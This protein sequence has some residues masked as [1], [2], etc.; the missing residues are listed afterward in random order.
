[1]HGRVIEHQNSESFFT[2]PL[3]E[4]TRAYLRGGLVL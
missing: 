4:S 3:H 2:S 1:M